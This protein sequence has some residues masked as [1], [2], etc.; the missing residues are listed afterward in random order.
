MRKDDCRLYGKT[1][2]YKTFLLSATS[3]SQYANHQ[4][5]LCSMAATEIII[6]LFFIFFWR[7]SQT[8]KKT[9]TFCVIILCL[10]SLVYL[11]FTSNCIS[12]IH[13]PHFIFM[14]SPFFLSFLYNHISLLDILS[15]RKSPKDQLILTNCLPFSL[16]VSSPQTKHV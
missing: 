6:F 7:L 9:F 14:L 12:T 1:V 2:C 16:H 10:Y 4:K 13:F 3:Y 15:Q 5:T 11:R 8:K